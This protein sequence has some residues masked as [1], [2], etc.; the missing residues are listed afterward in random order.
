MNPMKYRGNQGSNVPN[1]GRGPSP[2]IWGDCPWN[3]IKSGDVD[4]I[5][6]H[7]DFEFFPL[8]G[9]QTSEINLGQYKVYNTGATKVTSD[10]QFGTTETGGG[11]ISILCDTD[12]DQGVIGTQSCPF[13]LNTVS[14]KKLWFECRVALTAI[15]TDGNQLFVGLAENTDFTFG[16]A[17]PL[18]N[19]NA[20]SNAGAMVG[21]NRLEDGLG[22]LNASYADRATSWTNVL[23]SVGSIAALTWVKL[24]MIF[25][26]DNTLECLQFYVN[27]VKSSTNMTKAALAA[28]TYLDAGSLG[29]CMANFADSAGT[30]NYFY[31]DWW[32]GSQLL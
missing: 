26:P 22:V 21:F 5:A 14:S 32:R 15:L 10:A 24:G 2:Y 11:I 29:F 23:A 20:T 4:G 30:T 27:G 8:P 12:G 13:Y 6:I 28:L 1:T 16:A 31:C 19:A 9:T 7:D 17:Q 25:D 3:D 18:A